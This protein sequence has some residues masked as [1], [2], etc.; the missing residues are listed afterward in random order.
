MKLL[1]LIKNK[2][3]I[4]EKI[5]DIKI[6]PKLEDGCG[7][8]PLPLLE[9]PINSSNVV[10]NGGGGGGIGIPTHT[11]TNSFGII[12]RFFI[13]AQGMK[14]TIPTVEDILS[15]RKSNQFK[16]KMIRKGLSCLH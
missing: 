12:T 4:K 13:D 11:E 5:A 7:L 8:K 9:I 2:F 3:C 14:H 15:K 6:T 1:Q 16:Q 10:G